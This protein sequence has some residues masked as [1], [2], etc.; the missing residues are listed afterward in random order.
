MLRRNRS[1]CKPTLRPTTWNG[2]EDRRLMA[3]SQWTLLAI[4]HVGG[5]SNVTIARAEPFLCF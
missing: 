1:P 3:E 5:R 4:G 2:L